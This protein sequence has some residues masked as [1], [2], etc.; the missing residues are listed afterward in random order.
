MLSLPSTFHTT[1][2]I[3]LHSKI[4]TMSSIILMC[5]SRKDRINYQVQEARPNATLGIFH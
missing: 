5:R 1:E 2:I 3:R 4:S